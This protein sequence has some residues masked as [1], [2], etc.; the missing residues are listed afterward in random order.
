MSKKLMID[1]RAEEIEKEIK[2]MIDSLGK[3]INESLHEKARLLNERIEIC[4]QPKPKFMPKW[5]WKKIIGRLLYL[6]EIR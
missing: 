1:K 4:L 2:P 3:M 5:L 6:K